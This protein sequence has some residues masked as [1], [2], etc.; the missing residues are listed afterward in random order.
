[1]D[2]L[3]AN[4]AGDGSAVG[5]DGHPLADED[6]PVP[7]A[8]GLKVNKSVI[9]NVLDDQPNLIAVSCQHYPKRGIG[10]TRGDHIAVEVRLHFIRE[11]LCVI[12]ND[13]LDWAFIS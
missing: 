8:D 10:L 11:S 2:R 1:M 4:H 13:I 6:T 12:P 3:A 5:P 7:A 9:I